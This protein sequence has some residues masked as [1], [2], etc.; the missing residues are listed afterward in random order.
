MALRHFPYQHPTFGTAKNPKTSSH[1]K[2]SVYYWWYEYLKR[3]DDYRK[4]CAG[5]G[6]GKCAKVFE[7]FGDV[8]KQ[9]FK[10]WWSDGDR[11]ARLFAE[12]PTPTIRVVSPEDVEEGRF[13][14][15]NTL[16]LEVLI[17]QPN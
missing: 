17:H 13:Q 14:R 12:P 7:H 3:N 6:K 16:V 9:E 11:G 4:T 8:T 2:V 1:W 5:N 10:E 15:E